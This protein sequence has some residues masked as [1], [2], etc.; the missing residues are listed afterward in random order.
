MLKSDQLTVDD[1]ER[2]L[3]KLSAYKQ[4]HPGAAP[5][6]ILVGTWT[7]LFSTNRLTSWSRLPI[8][9]QLDQ[10]QTT[11]PAPQALN[12]NFVAIPAG[13]FAVKE[14]AIACFMWE[15]QT[16]AES[17]VRLSAAYDFTAAMT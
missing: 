11:P 10:F 12:D 7:K 14:L 5:V 6:F 13:S 3:K 4:A 9:Y 8:R 2:D 15:I 1:V 17:A 16:R